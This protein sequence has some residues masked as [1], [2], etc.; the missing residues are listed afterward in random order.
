MATTF[1]VKRYKAARRACAP[2]VAIETPD[3]P[4]TI[5]AL[6]A[7]L[8][9]VTPTLQWDVVR[10]LIALND[11]GQSAIGAAQIDLAAT[12][13]PVEMLAGIVKLPAVSVVFMLNAHRFLADVAVVQAIQN[14]RDIYK[15]DRRTLTLIGTSFSLPAEL[16]SDVVI[17][18][19]P[20]PTRDELG[21]VLDAQYANLKREVPTAPDLTPDER[22]AALDAVVGLAAFPGENAIAMSLSAR[23]L[24]TADLWE[25][26]IKGIESTEGLHVYKPSADDTTLDELAGLDNVV[27]FFRDLIAVKAFGAIVFIDEGDKAFA[28][29]MSDHTGDSGVAKDQAGQVLTY[30]EDHKA[31]GVL[32]AGLAG[33][34]KTQ[35]VKAIGAASG[36]PVLIFDLGGM[37]AGHVGESERAIRAALKVVTATAEGR[38]LFVMTCN[39][40]VLFTPELNR[41]F[42][43]QFFF[44]A[45]SADARRACWQTYARKCGLSPE[46]ASVPAGMDDGWTGAEIKRAC[47]RAA[48]HRKTVVDAARY[49]VPSAV[50]GA[51]QNAELRQ[52]AEGRFL[53]ASDPGWYRA[54]KQAAPA[55]LPASARSYDVG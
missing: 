16:A 53:S 7:G 30:M 31:I 24:A 6:R 51:K 55:A 4:A 38:T 15:S 25:H 2:F 42:S 54:P 23:G 29:A 14:L 1:T 45:M 22:A 27:E 12:V 21:A 11:S 52:Q 19:E 3:A 5:D 40:S 10:G 43:D 39:K 32:L 17:L 50:S 9:G 49:I 47:E 18:S 8:N 28:G 41:R 34:G 33:C 26:K 46:Q 36:K 13:N 20:L 35:L 44:D 48:L 37:K